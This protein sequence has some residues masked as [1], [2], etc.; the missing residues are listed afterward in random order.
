MET[1]II[2]SA[3]Q[4]D[5]LNQI[6]ESPQAGVGSARTITPKRSRRINTSSNDNDSVTSRETKI[7]KPGS[8]R[9]Q[10]WLNNSYLMG[11]EE[12]MEPSDLTIQPP[13]SMFNRLFEDETNLHLWEPFVD[14]TEEQQRKMLNKMCSQ[15][16]KELKTRPSSLGEE[17]FLR[18]EKKIRKQLV[19]FLDSPFLIE[20]DKEIVS[21]ASEQW[22]T[23][24]RQLKFQFTDSFHRMICHGICQ[25]YSLNSRSVELQGF[26]SDHKILFISKPAVY[27]PPEITLISYLQTFRQ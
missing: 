27:S 18:V 5:Q 23:N 21:F 17:S 13:A 6:I 11:F 2:L 24:R 14:V 1:Q 15:S 10:R 26:R 12:G 3:V 16:K 7:G 4:L 22:D 8:K 25:F 9:F 19:K 20:L